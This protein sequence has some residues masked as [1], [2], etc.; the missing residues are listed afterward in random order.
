MGLPRRAP[1][2]T[3]AA[4]PGQRTINARPPTTA[5]DPVGERSGNQALRVHD[6]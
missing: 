5:T 1:A 4:P 6:E 3:A 2:Q